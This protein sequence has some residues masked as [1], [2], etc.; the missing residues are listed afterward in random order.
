MSV[1]LPPTSEVD[2]GLASRIITRRN[3]IV[4]ASAASLSVAAYAGTKGRHQFEITH[5][6]LSI[7][8][9]PDAFVGFR[10]VQL[11]DIH[12]EEYTEPWFLEEMVAQ[13]NALDPELVLLTGDFVSRGPKPIPTAWQAAGVA[14]EILSTLKAPQRFAILGNHDV[15]V[16]ANHV[17]EPLTPD[18]N[19]AIPPYVNID[20]PVI[21]MCHEPD[22]ADH[23]VRHP[24]FPL[25]DLMLS[26]HTHGGQVRL[27]IIGPLILPPM[28]KRYIE[29]LFHFDHMQLYVNRGIGTV[30]LPF[31]LHCPAE[32]THITLV[33]AEDSTKPIKLADPQIVPQSHH[34]RKHKT[35]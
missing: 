33:R 20:E 4:G 11:S 32:I 14:A 17:I 30:G 35:S 6:T 31:R 16:G 22:Y 26:G 3:F 28:G 34:V 7:H 8:N 2:H 12:L 23:V 13:T 21:L 10:F 25:I 18:L 19:L 9:L 27:P 24:R 1:D 15:G 29:G 5:R